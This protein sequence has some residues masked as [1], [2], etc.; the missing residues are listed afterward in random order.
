MLR[1]NLINPRGWLLPLLAISL[2]GCGV[3]QS[4]TEGAKSAFNAVFYR[5]IKI[6]H[7]DFSARE[8][9]NTDA[10][11]STSL[12]EPVV[13]RVYQLRD[14]QIFDTLV[15]QQLLNEDET[16]LKADLLA[17]R[18]V[19]MKPGG[20][21]SLNMPVEAEARF[22]AVVGLFRHPESEN[23]RWKLVLARSDLMPDTARVIEAGDNHLTLIPLKE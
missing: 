16:L 6:L 20:D 3:T 4:V 13:V 5:Q 12:S 2:T 15:Y 7:L 19:V 23:N 10:R 18:D 21:V 8:A 1:T 22:V 9:L 14:R 17:S 11:E